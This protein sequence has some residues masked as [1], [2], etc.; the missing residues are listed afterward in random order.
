MNT[1]RL[2]CKY[3]VRTV[4]K[5]LIAEMKIGECDVTGVVPVVSEL[6]IGKLRSHDVQ[7]CELT[8]RSSISVNCITV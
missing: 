3:L 8:F 6:P 5:G 7:L 4:E 1:S 2:I